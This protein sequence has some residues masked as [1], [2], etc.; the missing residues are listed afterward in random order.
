[1][2]AAT[3][4]QGSHPFLNHLTAAFS[5]YELSPPHA[6]A[7]KYD[8]PR[9]WQTDAIERG[10][11]KIIQR[12]Y[13]AEDALANRRARSRDPH[14][15]RDGPSNGDD[16]AN[17]AGF[18]SRNR[19]KTGTPMSISLADLPPAHFTGMKSPPNGDEITP[20]PKQ[21]DPER[22]A[23][24]SSGS[25]DGLYH[26]HCPVCGHPPSRVRT[27]SHSPTGSPQIVPPGPLL[28]AAAEGGISAWDELTML[29]DQVQDVA[30]VCKVCH[31]LAF[32]TV[33]F[34][35]MRY[36]IGRRCR[37]L[38]AEDHNSRAKRGHDP[39]QG[40]N[41]LHGQCSSR[42]RDVHA[43][44]MQTLGRQIGTVRGRSHACITRGTSTL[45]LC[46][47]SSHTMYRSAQKGE[48]SFYVIGARGADCRS[49]NSVDRPWSSTSKAH[50]GT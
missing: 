48:Q 22:K 38:V 12:M 6:T 45:P 14:G 50:G 3:T 13:D 40:R 35:S 36:H 42:L 29:K 23:F 43:C 32:F 28:D 37:R 20:M 11:A 17:G 34:R 39:A 1:M 16:D 21:N 47:A 41:Q 9:D 24:P 27:T 46:L 49:V 25:D 10:L 19:S 2:A 7:P 26:N 30:R 15:D 44:S 4:M 8:G 18:S 31:R 5:L 33:P